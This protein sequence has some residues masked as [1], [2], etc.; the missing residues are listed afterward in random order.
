MFDENEGLL[1]QVIFGIQFPKLC[2]PG[3]ADIV[4]DRRLVALLLVR[5]FK[6][7]GGLVLPPLDGTQELAQIH[8]KVLEKDME[9]GR[10]YTAMHYPNW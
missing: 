9:A 6:K 5:H 1:D 8:A 10:F 7:F 4:G 3:V 2:H